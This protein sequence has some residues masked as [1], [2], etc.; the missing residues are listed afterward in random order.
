MPNKQ[1]AYQKKLH[2][3]R[4]AAEAEERKAAGIE[5][6][7]DGAAA[8]KMGDSDAVEKRDRAD[9]LPAPAL[10]DDETEATENATTDADEETKETPPE[11][12]KKEERKAPRMSKAQKKKMN[13]AAEKLR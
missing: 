13:D 3:K 11:E 1:K 10:S 9:S 12:E 2:L 4:L 8:D 6:P 7:E 5:T